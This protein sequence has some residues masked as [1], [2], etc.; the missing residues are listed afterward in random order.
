MQ[1]DRK[2]TNLLH[3][4]GS[5]CFFLCVYIIF[6]IT[7]ISPLS[8]FHTDIRLDEINVIPFWG[9]LDLILSGRGRRDQVCADQYHRQCPVV[10]SAGLFTAA[11]VGKVRGV[12]EDFGRRRGPVGTDRVYTAVSNPRDGC[13]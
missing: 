13:G 8:G 7:G 10:L 11:V 4:I 6:K 2:R 12:V 3:G 5:I 1:Q 9:I